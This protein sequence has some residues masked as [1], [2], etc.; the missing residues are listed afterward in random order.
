MNVGV[1]KNMGY[2]HCVLGVVAVEHFIVG[3]KFQ[4][5][6]L[7]LWLFGDGESD[8]DLTV[9]HILRSNILR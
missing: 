7:Y 4:T 8:R 6:R 3:N 2:M 1:S 9:V 5:K